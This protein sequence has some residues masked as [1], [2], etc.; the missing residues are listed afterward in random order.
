MLTMS[1]HCFLGV[2]V[3]NGRKQKREDKKGE[4]KRRMTEMKWRRRQRRKTQRL[5]CEGILFVLIFQ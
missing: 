4:I 2:L 3:Q 1:L 5:L